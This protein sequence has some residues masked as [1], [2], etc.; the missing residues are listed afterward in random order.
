LSNNIQYEINRLWMD[1]YT[2]RIDSKQRIQ[3]AEEF[4]QQHKG[5]VD[6]TK[7]SL[8]HPALIHKGR[9]DVGK[10]SI[11]E[12]LADFIIRAEKD[13]PRQVKSRDLELDHDDRYRENTFRIFEDDLDDAAKEAGE[14]IPA[15]S[16][17]LGQI[18]EETPGTKK[19]VTERQVKEELSRV[20]QYSEFY[21]TTF[22]EDYGK[23]YD[24]AIRRIRRLD[25]DRVR[26]CFQC[27]D[28]FYAHDLR[29]KVCD[30]Q[31]GL[32]EGGISSRYSACELNYKR[33][34]ELCRIR[35]RR[36][37]KDGQI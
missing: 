3:L 34:T 29:R 24:D 32:L 10:Q 23:D 16:K 5:K 15:Y 8:D 14:K 1:Y 4:I 11:A 26:T 25:L 17:S 13:K 28:G 37:V 6:F 30:R 36:K 35:E 22:A 20:K 12:I 19:P 33:E 9:Y 27:S 21:A 18:Y 31:R 2:S 7:Q